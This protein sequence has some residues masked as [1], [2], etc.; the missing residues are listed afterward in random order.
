M[1]GRLIFNLFYFAAK[2]ACFFTKS[3]DDE[4]HNRAH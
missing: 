4:Q 3:N 1:F 2:V